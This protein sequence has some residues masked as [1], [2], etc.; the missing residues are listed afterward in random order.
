MCLFSYV[1]P[2]KAGMT[3]LFEHQDNLSIKPI[4]ELE[5]AHEWPV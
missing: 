5:S 4:L 3:I 2:A 1:M